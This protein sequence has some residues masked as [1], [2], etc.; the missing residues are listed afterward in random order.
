MGSATDESTSTSSVSD[1]CF[2]LHSILSTA[3]RLLHSSLP[4]SPALFANH[5]LDTLPTA[6]RASYEHTL[7]VARTE[8]CGGWCRTLTCLFLDPASFPAL[9]LKAHTRTECWTTIKRCPRTLFC[10]APGLS[11]DRSAWYLGRRRAHFV[12]VDFQ[13]VTPRQEFPL[14]PLRPI[15]QL[16]FNTSHA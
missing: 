7:S 3:G 12:C 11:F 15:P 4:A 9:F 2:N 1:A 14:S 5:P 6:I 16:L 13:L 8:I 10:L